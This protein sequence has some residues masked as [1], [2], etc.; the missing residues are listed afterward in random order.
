MGLMGI[1]F[2]TRWLFVALHEGKNNYDHPIRAYNNENLHPSLIKSTSSLKL[3]PILNRLVGKTVSPLYFL[4]GAIV[5]LTTPTS[6]FY[7]FTSVPII[8]PIQKS[9]RTFN[10]LL[11]KPNYT[12]CQPLHLNCWPVGLWCSSMHLRV[13]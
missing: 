13:N 1:V 2:M 10:L 6:V 5:E 11:D 3:C 9:T 7:V 12:T 4:L 8:L